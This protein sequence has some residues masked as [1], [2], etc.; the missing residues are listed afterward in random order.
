MHNPLPE[1][2]SIESFV[3]Y[4]LEEDLDSYNHTDLRELMY[5]LRLSAQKV[6]RELDGYGLRLVYRE[7]AKRVRGVHDSDHDR[8][9]GEGSEKTCGGSGQDQINGFAGQEG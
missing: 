5:S 7:K 8:W 6:R 9:W 3:E 4:C 1:Y 2:G